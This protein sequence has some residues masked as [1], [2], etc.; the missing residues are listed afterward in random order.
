MA[1]RS[2]QFRGI[3]AVLRAYENANIPAFAIKCENQL[4]MK[5]PD[6]GE[7]GKPSMEAGKQFLKQALTELSTGGG[8]ATYTLCIY[9]DLKPGEKIN[10]KTP[11]DMS[12]NFKTE[13]DYEEARGRRYGRDDYSE[14]LAGI[15][16][17]L[18]ELTKPREEEEEEPEAIGGVWG[19]LSKLLDH[20]QI[21]QAISGK[22]VSLIDGFKLFTSPGPAA[23]IPV[24]HAAK[25]A[26]IDD[27]HN[28]EQLEKIR[29]A[30][31]VL[32]RVD[33]FLGDH[34]A[35]IA[36]IAAKDPAKY[37]LLISML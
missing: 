19:T 25:I 34:L 23:V 4:I 1:S 33:P 28:M 3:P 18:S 7:E 21:A 14:R 35:A 6:S 24:T 8:L 20:P 11:F 12:F 26:G 2:V 37:N 30:V 15:E 29:K 22:V 9:E 16:K 32:A 10:S 27:K 13:D 36:E 31:D 5:F 17:Q